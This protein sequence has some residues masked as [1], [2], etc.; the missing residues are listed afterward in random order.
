ME[1]TKHFFFLMSFLRSYPRRFFNHVLISIPWRGTVPSCKK[2]GRLI[3]NKRENF[4]GFIKGRLYV[5]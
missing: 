2:Y 5:H 1:I 4:W 3:K